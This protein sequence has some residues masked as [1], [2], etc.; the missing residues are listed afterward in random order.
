ME[1][2]E[3][4]VEDSVSLTVKGKVYKTV[5][6]PTMMHG[7]ETWAAKIA[8]KK[9]DVAK[10]RMLRWMCGVTTMD[11]IRNEKIRGTTKVGEISKKMQ[12]RRLK[13]G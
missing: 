5:V 10:T 8:Q 3:E 2:L 9:L 11:R 13:R 7:A 6:G 1:T 4:G 12:N